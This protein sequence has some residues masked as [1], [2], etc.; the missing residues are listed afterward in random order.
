M[1]ICECSHK[2]EDHD[3]VKSIGQHYDFCMLCPCHY[4]IISIVSIK[5][6]EKENK[7]KEAQND[8]SSR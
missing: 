2:Q 8:V 1:N 6:K 5:K 3:T 4:F 7:L